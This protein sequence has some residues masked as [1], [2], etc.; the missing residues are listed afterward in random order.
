MLAVAVPACL[1]LSVAPAAGHQTDAVS[2][3]ACHVAGLQL[4]APVY[5]LPHVLPALLRLPLASMTQH[6]LPATL[7]VMPKG[8]TCQCGSTHVNSSTY[9]KGTAEVDNHAMSYHI[10]MFAQDDK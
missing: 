9:Q 3:A 5:W 4:P 6:A 2:A 8:C 10:N 7:D 1:L